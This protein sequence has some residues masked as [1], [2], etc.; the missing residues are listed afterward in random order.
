[1]PGINRLGLVGVIIFAGCFAAP[2]SAEKSVTPRVVPPVL[3]AMHGYDETSIFVK[4]REGATAN[5]RA[6]AHGLLKSSQIRKYRILNRLEQV[7]LPPGLS[8]ERAVRILNKLPFVEYAHADY[9]IGIDQAPNDAYFTEQWGLD[10]TG[11]A[12]NYGV[13]TAGSPGADI[14]WVE[15]RAAAAGSGV[16]IA[17]LDTGV[18]YRHTDIGPNVWLNTAEL[19]GVAN[20][21][22][23]NNGYVDDIRGWDF[24]NNDN[25]PLDGNGHGTHVSGIIA[26]VT[27]NAK[28]TAGVMWNGQI[29]ALKILNDSG[30]GTLSDAIAAIEYAL[31]KGI[32]ISNN[33][34][35]YSEVL[36]AELADHNALH[37]AIQAAQAAN[38]LF[39]A[40][41]GN[42]STDT[43]VAP[44]YPS[45]FDLDNIVSVAATDNT[46]GLAWFSSFGSVSVDLAAPG[47]NVMST[48]KL[49]AQFEDYAWL[50]GT[51]MA[52][53]HVSAVAGLILGLQPDWSYQQIRNRLLA[54]ARPVPALAGT[55]ASGAVLNAYAALDGL[56]L[57]LNVV[58]DIEP[59]DPTN[60]V[61]TEGFYSDQVYLALKSTSTATGDAV[62]FDAASVDQA[63]LR[64]GPAGATP[65]N[66]PGVLE[67]V[68]GDSDNDLVV[69]FLIAETGITCEFPDAVTLS[70]TTTGGQEFVGSDS[71]TTPV[72]PSCH[73]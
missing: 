11:Q 17:V 35:G 38:H 62:D 32:R 40:A 46:D 30:E 61:E 1:M 70:G 10:N 27:D 36:A 2:V 28:G 12:S 68:D 41:A 3:R 21:D 56:P 43:D 13:F 60:Y 66:P 31:E 52:T 54:T 5:D 47:D 49:F 33:S 14:D 7:A 71:V 51:S 55:S 25:S 19:N 53:P 34:W 57:P 59:G 67:D 18:D 8:V 16:V 4:F 26:A 73:P 48:Y 37:D 23:D 72:C 6:A 58:I 22:D 45:S 39:V 24:V 29:M 44:H 15:A 69:K 42:L 63:T 64:L 65:F 9:K 50:S 20:V